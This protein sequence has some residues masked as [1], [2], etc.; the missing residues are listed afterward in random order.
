MPVLERAAA[1]L[2]DNLVD[3]S[4]SNATRLDRVDRPA[5][6]RD[7]VDAV[8]EREHPGRRRTRRA[9]KLVVERPRITEKPPHRMLAIERPKRPPIR[10]VEASNFPATRRETRPE[11]GMS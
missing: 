4:E 3:A 2:D 8:V 9:C 7:D 11:A 6:A 5:A 10:L 1:R